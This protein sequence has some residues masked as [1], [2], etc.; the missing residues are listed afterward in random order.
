VVEN[1]SDEGF[2]FKNDNYVIRFEGIL[3]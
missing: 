3:I 1:G 2:E